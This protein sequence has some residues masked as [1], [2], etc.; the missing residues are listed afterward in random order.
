MMMYLAGL[1]GI[2]Q[3]LTEA[4]Q[5]DGANILQTIFKIKIPL[6]KPYV[7][8]CSLNSVI[9]AIGVFDVVFVLTKRRTK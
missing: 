2:P 5:I 1:Q 3:E 4:A 7:W 9:S 6:L 8:L